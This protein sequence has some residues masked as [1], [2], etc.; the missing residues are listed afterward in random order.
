MRE[1][2]YAIEKDYVSEK[3]REEEREEEGEE[4]RVC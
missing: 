4:E 2:V 3:E 1:R